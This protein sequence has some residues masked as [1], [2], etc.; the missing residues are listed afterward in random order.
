VRD[1]SVTAE[2]MFS[3]EEEPCSTELVTLLFSLFVR[4]VGWLV[5]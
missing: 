4:L 2:E 3:S 1:F 5:G